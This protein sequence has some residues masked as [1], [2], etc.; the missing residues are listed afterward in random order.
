[1]SMRAFMARTAG[2]LMIAFGAGHMNTLYAQGLQTDQQLVS[3]VAAD[4]LLEVRLGQFAAKKAAS[5]AVKQ[6]AQRMVIDHTSMQKQWMAAAEKNKLQ[7]KADLGPQHLQQAEQLNSLS[8][9]AFDKAY[10]AAMVQ[11]HQAAV[12]SF[13]TERNAPHAADIRQLIEAGL[14]ALQEHL[15]LG[16]QLAS[17]VGAEVTATTGTP[18][19]PPVATQPSPT[20][21]TT[22]AVQSVRA[23]SLFIREVDASNAAELRLG[24]L[25]QTRATD[26]VVKRFAQKMV[27]DHSEMQR[28]WFA[29]SSRNGL[30]FT[31]TLSPQQQQQVTRLE[32]LSGTDFDR[33]YMAAM[34]Q[35]H[36]DNVNA[37]Q[38]RGRTAQSSEVRTLAERGLPALQEHLALAQQVARQVGAATPT[39]VATDTDRGKRGNVNADAKFIREVDADNFLE[40]RLG[41]LAEK[42]AR[43]EAV[44]Q[45]GRKMVEDHTALQEQWTRMAKNNGMEFKSGMGRRH[46]AKL[47]RLEKMSG[48]EFDREYMTL[49][50]Q[51]NNDYLSYF[52]KEGR[53]ANSAPVRQ[54][55]NRGIPVLERHLNEAKQIGARV[56]ADTTTSRYG[57]ISANQK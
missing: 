21:P 55:V 49:M 4:N 37:F 20:T 38:N 46:Q 14:P 28:E 24:R 23:D 43:N 33:A 19:T 29:V 51:N 39:Q 32:R 11:N 36:Q 16:Q 7:F 56:G 18:T 53:G 41:R 25:A 15:A 34:V 2:G 1:M 31:G 10:M 6:F 48:R 30:P 5:P 17:Q 42:K 13:Q 45:F 44:K 35:N 26:S 9:A 12:N 57:R 3:Q 47:T 50:V 22:P 52:R 54:L 8:G 40:I 27:T